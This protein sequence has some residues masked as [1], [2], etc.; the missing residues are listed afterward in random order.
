MTH[1]GGLMETLRL[2]TALQQ[3]G[4]YI[5]LSGL[6]P[7]ELVRL[8]EMQGIDVRGRVGTLHQTSLRVLMKDWKIVAFTDQ[9][10]VGVTVYLL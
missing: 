7:L 10:N 6:K 9:P 2:L 3:W 4:G 1:G 8:G 5:N